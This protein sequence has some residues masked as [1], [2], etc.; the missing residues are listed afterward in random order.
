M[1][2]IVLSA[3]VPAP[4]FETLSTTQTGS[5]ACRLADPVVSGDVVARGVRQTAV[6]GRGQVVAGEAAR[7]LGGEGDEQEPEQRRSPSRRAIAA[8]AGTEPANSRLRRRSRIRVRRGA[9]VEDD[10]QQRDA[11]DHGEPAE[12]DRA[13]VSADAGAK[14][15]RTTLPGALPRSPPRRTGAVP[16]P[17][18]R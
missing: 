5:P 2:V 18:G 4:K 12:D 6:G 1:P 9:T 16:A 11:D 8:S 3:L 14:S 13:L 17:A 7:E 15:H 10:Q